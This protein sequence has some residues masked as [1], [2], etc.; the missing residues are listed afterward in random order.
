MLE[1]FMASYLIPILWVVFAILIVILVVFTLRTGNYT[2]L[3]TIINN[4]VKA[5]EQKWGSGTGAIK[6]VEASTF[7]NNMLP[8]YLKIVFTATFINNLLE[9]I[10]SELKT[11]TTTVTV[12]IMTIAVMPAVIKKDVTK[13]E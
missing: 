3:K 1:Q 10:V 9:T 7:I 5:A 11:A 4:A 8:W 6:Y 2:V 13:S 12:P